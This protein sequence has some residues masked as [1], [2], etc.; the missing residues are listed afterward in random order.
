MP[1]PAQLKEKFEKAV[2]RVN[3]EGLDNLINWLETETDYFSAPASTRF[4]GNYQGGLM[5]H[6]LHVLEF[7]LTNLN[8]AM[9][10]K[11]ELKEL[12]ES[13]VICSLFHDVCKVNQYTWGE[14]KWTKNDSTGKWMSYKTYGFKDDLPMGHGEK[15]IYYITKHMELT[16]QEILAIRWHM[17]SSEQ[18]TTIDGLT[19]YAFQAAW[20][21]PLVKIIHVADMASVLVGDTIDYKSRAQ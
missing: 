9:K 21:Y 5:E 4:H 2:S 14:E 6:S 15:S 12:Q 11:P 3:R 20:E 10:Y 13:V 19:K 16:K 1:T 8:W 17:G 18:G 7:A